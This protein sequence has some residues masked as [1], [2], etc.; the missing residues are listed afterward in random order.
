MLTL[1]AVGQ[2]W[3]LGPPARSAPETPAP[4]VHRP[5][6]Q[7]APPA[8]DA[9]VVPASPQALGIWGDYDPLL[10]VSPQP[11]A[12]PF[13]WA[14]LSLISRNVIP[15]SSHITVLFLPVLP[16]PETWLFE[17][18]ARATA[19]H[20]AGRVTASWILGFLS[21][22]QV[23]MM[24]CCSSPSPS[25]LLQRRQQNKTRWVLHLP[26]N[27]G[28]MKH[29]GMPLHGASGRTGLWPQCSLWM[30]SPSALSS[31]TQRLSGSC[32]A[33]RPGRS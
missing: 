9:C 20:L 2:P 3:R 7:P 12:A 32:K 26:A 15:S 14:A 21:V 4:L 18:A 10:G 16:G 17:R 1:A 8:A 6:H 31:P 33:T 24:G 28:S 30:E 11:E 27:A 22:Y 23:V 25:S 19:M 13:C 5:R 29:P